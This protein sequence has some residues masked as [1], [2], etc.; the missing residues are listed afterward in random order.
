MTL[1][2]IGV[3]TSVTVD[4]YPEHAYVNAAY[5]DAVQ[6]AAHQEHAAAAGREQVAGG[7]GIGDAR[8]VEAPALV[9]DVD[10]DALAGHHLDVHR[11]LRAALQAVAVDDRVRER[12]GHRHGQVLEP[13]G[14]QAHRPGRVD[15]AIHCRRHGVARTGYVKAQAR[16]AGAR[17][18]RHW[19]GIL[20]GPRQ[21]AL[22]SVAEGRRGARST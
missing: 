17:R 22:Q 19:V 6:Q 5:L 1:P 11:Y 7:G 15:D 18:T 9:A 2:L 13:A 20:A 4:K 21:C 10:G 12:L 8:D 16:G 3:T 14:R